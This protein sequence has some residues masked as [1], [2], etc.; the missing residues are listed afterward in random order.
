[1]LAGNIRK[2]KTEYANPIQ[3]TLN[4][5]DEVVD[6]NARIGKPIHIK[7]TGQINCVAC[8]N[9][10]KKAFGQG[11]CFPCFRDSPMNSECIIRPELCEAHLGKGRDP[12][13]EEK[14]HNQPHVVYL[15]VS[16]G[17]K[18]GVT[19]GDQIPTR[20]IDQGAWKAIKI[21]DVPYRQL[22]GEIESGLK[23]LIDDKTHW[24]AMLKNVLAEH[25]DL[26]EKKDLMLNYVP[27]PLQELVSDDDTIWEMKYPVQKYPEKVSSTNLEKTPEI[28]ATLLGIRGQYLIFNENRV[29]NIRKYSGYW[30]EIN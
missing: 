1:M 7:W 2:M 20:W 19:R 23:G 5:G 21:A 17:M 29:I 12:E 16:S 10:I 18:V 30:W 27:G 6:M 26:E 25:I 15:A 11:F 13:W 9:N 4:I 8:G 14:Y 22:A 3:Y 24:Q 28:K